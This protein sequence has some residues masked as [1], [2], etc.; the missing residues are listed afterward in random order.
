LGLPIECGSGGRTKY[1]RTVRELPKAHWVDA[2]CVG[3][4]TPEHIK[5]RGI[6][7]LSITAYGHGCRQMCLM[8]KYGFP[9][10]DPK[11]KHPKHGF[12]TGDMVK[13]IV[14]VPLKRAGTHVG[15]MSAKASGAFTIATKS[16]AVPDI[17]KNYCRKLQRADGYGYSPFR[18]HE[19][20]LNPARRGCF[21]SPP[22]LKKGVPRKGRRW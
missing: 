5:V 13:A 19:A 15:R 9:R 6:I 1:N 17:G 18:V 20:G 8:N 12:K 21:L 4:S 10:T 22:Y 16:G 2:A 7:P 11:E 14:P 3:E